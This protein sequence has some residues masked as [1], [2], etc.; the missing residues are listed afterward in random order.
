MMEVCLMTNRNQWNPPYYWCRKG[1]P[2]Y[3]HRY[4]RWLHVLLLLLL[5][6]VCLLCCMESLIPKWAALPQKY[7][8][9]G[10]TT[11]FSY[12]S[13]FCT[14][15]YSNIAGNSWW[16]YVISSS[17]DICLYSERQKQSHTPERTQPSINKAFVEPVCWCNLATLWWKNSSPA[18]ISRS[19]CFYFFPIEWCFSDSTGLGCHW[20][21]NV[22]I[23]W[24]WITNEFILIT[25]NGKKLVSFYVLSVLNC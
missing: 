5:F 1:R 22:F 6:L 18:K 24:C 25:C 19:I 2:K 14:T 8:L 20:L 12:H 10:V 3:L 11:L 9:I 17:F 23:V 4:G 15:N 16:K 7:H 13:I 21:E